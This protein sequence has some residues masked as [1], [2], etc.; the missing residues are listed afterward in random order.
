M[1]IKILL[2]LLSLQLAGCSTVY[3]ELSRDRRDAPWDPRG[4]SSLMDQIP[5]EDSGALRRCCGH[6]RSCEAHQTP[7]C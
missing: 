7:R 1:R 4:S 2:V 5:N 3:T 6:L